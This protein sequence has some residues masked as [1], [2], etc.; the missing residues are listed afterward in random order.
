MD[1]E[2]IIKIT[3]RKSEL[4]L[5]AL[6]VGTL[7]SL[8][9]AK[10]ES[11]YQEQQ[12]GSAGSPQEGGAA[13]FGGMGGN[14]GTEEKCVPNASLTC[15]E[16]DVYWQDSCWTLGQLKEDCSNKQVCGN[17]QCVY[18]CSMATPASGCTEQNCSFY[19]A[20]DYDTCKWNINFGTPVVMNEKVHLE[21]TDLVEAKAGPFSLSPACNGDFIAQYKVELLPNSTGS[22]TVSHRNQNPDFSGIT[23]THY[24]DK[25]NNIGLN[26]NGYEISVGNVDLHTQKKLEVRKTAYRLELYVDNAFASYVLCNQ[27]ETPTPVYKMNI[28]A[29]SAVLPQGMKIDDVSLYCL[30]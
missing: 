13:G 17:G 20:F 22:V 19:D 16:G 14:G 30:N 10:A 9:C 26:C 12:G 29:G 28:S 18:D 3:R 8:G 23:I 15:H 6:L 25:N 21:G 4:V 1:L 11:D 2:S 7:S 5:P 24:P 27:T